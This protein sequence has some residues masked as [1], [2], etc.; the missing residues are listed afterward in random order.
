[1]AA[2]HPHAPTEPKPPMTFFRSGAF[3]FPGQRDFSGFVP[4]AGILCSTSRRSSPRVSLRSQLAG[5]TPSAFSD[6]AG[7]SA[8]DVSASGVPCPARSSQR[9]ARVAGHKTCKELGNGL[10]PLM[11]PPYEK[12]IRGARRIGPVVR[13]A[14]DRRSRTARLMKRGQVPA[15]EPRASKMENAQK[16]RFRSSAPVFISLTIVVARVTCCG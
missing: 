2:H 15:F 16:S 13:N 10:V 6:F 14:S 9:R 8:G 1:M 12:G 4:G 3:C 7:G 11:F 5:K